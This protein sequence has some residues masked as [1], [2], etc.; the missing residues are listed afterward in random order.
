MLL[1]HW[2]YNRYQTTP[3]S[4]LWPKGKEKHQTLY[5]F[6]ICF[7]RIYVL[8]RYQITQISHHWPNQTKP[9]RNIKQKPNNKTCL[10]LAL[11]SFN[12]FLYYRVDCKRNTTVCSW[13][14]H[15][16]TWHSW[17]Y[18]KLLMQYIRLLHIP[19]SVYTFILHVVTSLKTLY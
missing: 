19:T 7:Y 1:S 17:F 11:S 3:F 8:K 12:T 2:C 14:C 16:Y 18:I 15:L 9:N 6:Q 5:C 4:H 10:Y 13:I